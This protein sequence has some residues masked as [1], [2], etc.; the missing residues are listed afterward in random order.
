MLHKIKEEYNKES[1]LITFK[2]ETDEN[3]LKK[4]A[5]Q[6]IERCKSDVVVANLMQLRYD[7]IHLYINSSEKKN[8]EESTE[9][10]ELIRKTKEEEYIESILIRR[11]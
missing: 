7:E 11:L 5:L 4:K 2:L 9:N 10:H 6:A 8:K 3:L 1:F